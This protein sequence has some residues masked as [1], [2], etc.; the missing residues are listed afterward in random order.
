MDSYRV[1]STSSCKTKNKKRE[2][3]IFGGNPLKQRQ[4]TLMK[5]FENGVERNT[6]N[7]WDRPYFLKQNT[8]GHVQKLV[9]TQRSK[10]YF[11]SS[12]VAFRC[13]D[14]T[15]C[16]WRHDA[17]SPL[18]RQGCFGAAT[19]SFITVQTDKGLE[20]GKA[21]LVFCVH[22]T[23]KIQAASK[24]LEICISHNNR[25]MMSLMPYPVFCCFEFL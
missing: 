2:I 11:R 17:F 3:P 9:N 25:M 4:N 7:Y 20:E 21:I 22:R 12:L 18:R 10:G 5:A 6:T 15:K 24:T 8:T 23:H 14:N 1:P 19:V 16:M 13:M